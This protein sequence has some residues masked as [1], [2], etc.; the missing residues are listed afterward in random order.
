ME[1]EIPQVE[2][3]VTSVRHSFDRWPA[4]AG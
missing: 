3:I 4:S 1:A 2:G